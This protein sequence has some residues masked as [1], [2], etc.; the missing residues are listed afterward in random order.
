VSREL[1]AAIPV[2][3]PAELRLFNAVVFRTFNSKTGY[4]AAT[5]GWCER[6]NPE[7]MSR[8]LGQAV[9]TKQIWGNAYLMVNSMTAGAPKHQ[10]YVKGPFTEVW[11]DR[12]ELLKFIQDDPSLEAVT[13]RFTKY[14][15]YAEFLGYELA[16]DMEMLGL[17]HDPVDKYTWANPGPGA[18]RG[19]NFVFGRDRKFQQ[20]V[21]KFL[22]EMRLLFDESIYFLQPHIKRW[23]MRC[24]ENG[25]CETSKYASVLTTG[26]AKRRFK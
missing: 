20:P 12:H 23:D 24:I 15:G 4:L 2:D 11:H 26:R 8:W 16:L 7:T 6:F 14:Q 25:L 13:K 5:G 10:M 21:G 9:K 19:L 17:L 22:D 1:N 18:R 3:A